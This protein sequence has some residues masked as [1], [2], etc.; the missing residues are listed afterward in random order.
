MLLLLLLPFGCTNIMGQSFF[1]QP[2][3][4]YTWYHLGTRTESSPTK[5]PAVSSLHLPIEHLS[6]CFSYQ[7]PHWT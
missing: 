6:S 3:N 1:M 4:S 5:D 7:S 2:A